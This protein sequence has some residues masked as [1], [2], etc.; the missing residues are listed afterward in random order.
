[1]TSSVGP[2]APFL[3]ASFLGDTD[4]LVLT[5]PCRHAP[6]SV[7]GAELLPG[8][9]SS[10]G[11]TQNYQ[12]LSPCLF[13]LLSPPARPPLSAPAAMGPWLGTTATRRVPSSAGLLQT[14]PPCSSLPAARRRT[15]TRARTP[16]HRTEEA[17]GPLFLPEVAFMYR[18]VTWFFF[19]P[20]PL[21][22][23]HLTH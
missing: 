12:S 7:L 10:G 1:M 5:S 19:F 3:C 14:V 17:A 4:L 23:K 11:N 13:F 8:L 6:W 20:L 21:P 9:L 18:I 2:G 22:L 15:P 16:R